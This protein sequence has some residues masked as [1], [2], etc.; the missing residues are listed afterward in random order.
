VTVA[1]LTFGP[2]TLYDGRHRRILRGMVPADLHG[3]VERAFNVADVEALV[4]LY[5]TDARM[6]GDDGTVIIGRD[7]IRSLYEDLTAL[8][9]RISLSTRYA[10]EQGDIALLSNQWSL[11]IDGAPV[12]GAITAEVARRQPDGSW[13]YVIDNP[14][15]APAEAADLTA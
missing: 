5:E 10:V 8:G 6:M 9:G 4:G 7:A 14:Y 3:A 11:E 2:R 12:A 13:R 1:D 15:G